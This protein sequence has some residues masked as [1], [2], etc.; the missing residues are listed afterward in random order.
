MKPLVLML[1]IF[2]STIC[3]AEDWYEYE[4]DAYFYDSI[5]NVLYFVGPIANSPV[6]NPV[7]PPEVPVIHQLPPFI[8]EPPSRHDD[9]PLENVNTSWY[10]QWYWYWFGDLVAPLP[11][12]PP[13]PKY[14][15][16]MPERGHFPDGFAVLPF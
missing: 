11:P 2:S 14:W 1:L 12:P 4:G 13:A 16:P 10:W 6:R 7:R 3:L 8:D 9:D 5:D 15:S